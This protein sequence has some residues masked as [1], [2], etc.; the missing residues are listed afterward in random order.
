MNPFNDP[1]GTKYQRPVGQIRR[2]LSTSADGFQTWLRRAV[3]GR[4]GNTWWAL[5]ANGEK[6]AQ[7]RVTWIRR[8]TASDLIPNG[9]HRQRLEFGAQVRAA[10]EILARD[11]QDE[12][13]AAGR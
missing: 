13:H 10:A 6:I 7:I 2:I 12:D 5:F 1:L 8:F 9:V 3:A 4:A 11:H